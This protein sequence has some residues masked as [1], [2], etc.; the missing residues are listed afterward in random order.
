MIKDKTLEMT[1]MWFNIPKQQIDLD[2]VINVYLYGSRT[3]ECQTEVSDT[4]YIIVYNQENDISD[5]LEANFADGSKL[6]AT[7]Y[8]PKHFQKLLDEHDISVIEC[9]FLREDW[10]YETQKFN[11]NLDLT[12]LRKSLSSVSSNSWV[13]CKKKI[14]QGDDWIGIKSMFHSLRILDFGI[15]LAKE[16]K[17]DF[18]NTYSDNLVDYKK[19]FDL[20][21]DLST[22]IYWE[23]LKKEFQP[24]YNSLKSEFRIVAPL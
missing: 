16:G 21:Q 17:I 2:K 11:F 8:S 12:K 23:D 14:K 7:L 9:F 6:N 20:L 22:Y 10:K 4:D 19:Y 5:T 1:L 18:K 24:I 13:K 15:Q 3:Y